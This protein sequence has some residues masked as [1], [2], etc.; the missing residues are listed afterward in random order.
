MLAKGTGG[1]ETSWDFQGYWEWLMSRGK[2]QNHQGQQNCLALLLGFVAP[3]CTAL[4]AMTLQSKAPA[5]SNSW[6][7]TWR[8]ASRNLCRALYDVIC[9]HAWLYSAST[10]FLLSCKCLWARSFP[11]RRRPQT[12]TSAKTRGKEIYHDIYLHICIGTACPA[13]HLL[14]QMGCNEF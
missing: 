2:V 11:V 14:D 10:F 6:G 1:R 8:M 13:Q 5:V 7:R 9:M 12:M 4:P 3:L